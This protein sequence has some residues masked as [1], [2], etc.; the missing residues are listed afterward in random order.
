MT[1]IC[2]TLQMNNKSE[3]SG[4]DIFPKTRLQKHDMQHHDNSARQKYVLSDA[5]HTLGGK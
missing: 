4:D 5:R 1:T 3:R 2:A